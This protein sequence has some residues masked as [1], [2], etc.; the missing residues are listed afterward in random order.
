MYTHMVKSL[1]CDIIQAEKTK[2]ITHT[3]ES[4]KYV[5]NIGKINGIKQESNSVGS[6][7]CSTSSSEF[8][9]S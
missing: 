8:P 3:E 7:I 4:L 1:S 2:D 6:S 5:H 9:S